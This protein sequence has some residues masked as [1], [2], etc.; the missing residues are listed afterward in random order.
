M[1][2][3]IVLLAAIGCN[4]KQPPEHAFGKSVET[5]L[6]NANG[7]TPAFPGQTRAPSVLSKDHQILY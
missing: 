1:R 4:A 3:A 2:C 7:Q 6:P 5:A